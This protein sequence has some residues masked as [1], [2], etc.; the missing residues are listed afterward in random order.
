MFFN[1]VFHQRRNQ[2][3]AFFGGI[4][5]QKAGPQVRSFRWDELDNQ[6]EP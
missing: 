3:Q 1:F 6:D 5:S 2:Q 4:F